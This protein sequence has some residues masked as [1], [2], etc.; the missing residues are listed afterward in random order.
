MK[1][2]T[3]Q[4]SEQPIQ[5]EICYALPTQQKLISMSVEEGTTASVAVAESNLVSTFP[6][7]DL[8]NLNLAIFST[9]VEND[10]VLKEGDR[11]EILRPLL[12]DPKE[13]RKRRAAEMKA[14]KEAQKKLKANNKTD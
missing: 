9:K 14:K 7:I 10:Y 3:N 12:A 2:T 6:E 8:G 13:V 1:Q 11:I 4:V 5:I